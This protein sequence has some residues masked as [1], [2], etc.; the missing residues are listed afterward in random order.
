[1]M[2]HDRYG[3]VTSSPHGEVHVH[4]H[5]ED[6]PLTDNTF[7]NDVRSKI[8]QYRRVYADRPDPIVFIALTVNTW[9]RLYDDF[10]L[11]LFLHTHRE[12]TVL[13]RELLEYVIHRSIYLSIDT[14]PSVDF[15]QW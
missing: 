9:V 5:F 13:A 7:K 3:R 11:L 4:A 12:G 1:M 8:P 14:Y 2:T 15:K 6:T 10:I